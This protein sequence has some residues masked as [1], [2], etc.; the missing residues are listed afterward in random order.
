MLE[1]ILSGKFDCP[2]LKCLLERL[3]QEKQQK[4]GHTKRITT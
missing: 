1:T 3:D 4:K 2:V